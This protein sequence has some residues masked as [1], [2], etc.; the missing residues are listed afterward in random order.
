MKLGRRTASGCNPFD[1]VLNRRQAVMVCRSDRSTNGNRILWHRG[2]YHWSDLVVRTTNPHRLCEAGRS[3]T[4]PT[5]RSSR[6]KEFEHDGNKSFRLPHSLRSFSVCRHMENSKPASSEWQTTPRRMSGGCSRPGLHGDLLRSRGPERD[7]SH[8]QEDTKKSS[9]VFVRRLGRRATLSHLLPRHRQAGSKN[10]GSPH[11]RCC[12]QRGGAAASGVAG[13]YGSMGL[14][15]SA[16]IVTAFAGLSLRQ[17]RQV[18]QG[19]AG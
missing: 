11:E 18:H 8:G 14:G 15:D 10:F 9:H 6:L 16:I 2:S 19:R 3:G 4:W 1:A 13:P 17:R 7:I 12:K 5:H